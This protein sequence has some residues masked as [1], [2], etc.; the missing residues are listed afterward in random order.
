MH[1]GKAL[2]AIIREHDRAKNVITIVFPYTHHRYYFWHI[3]HISLCFCVLLR[4]IYCELV[5]WDVVSWWLGC[6]V[7]VVW[8]DILGVGGLGCVFLWIVVYR[9]Y[10]IFFF[11]FT[12]LIYSWILGCCMLVICDIAW[13]RFGIIYCKLVV[14]DTYFFELLCMTFT[15]YFFLFTFLIY[16]WILGCWVLVV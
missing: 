15:N 8:D 1:D 4:M 2:N 5:V 14:R 10:K 9:I 6:C 7:M 13:W 11:S 3:L 12:F 16:S